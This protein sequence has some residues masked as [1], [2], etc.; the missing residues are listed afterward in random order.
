MAAIETSELTSIAQPES[1]SSRREIFKSLIAAAMKVVNAQLD[2]FSGRVADALMQLSDGST[3]A[4]EASI[5]FN[6]SNLLKKNV[7]AFHFLTAGVIQKALRQEIE[8]VE[9]PAKLVRPKSGEGLSLVPY[10]DMDKKLLL[11]NISRPLESANAERLTAMRLRLAHLLDRDDVSNNQNPFRPEVFLSAIN[12]AWRD[13]NPDGGAHM[14]F[15]PLLKQ[16]IFLDLGVVYDAIN[17]ELIDADILPELADHYNIKKTNANKESKK[18]KEGLDA[19]AMRQLRQ[20]L[21]AHGAMPGAPALPGTTGQSQFDAVPMIPSIPVADIPMIP[22]L[23]GVAAAPGT[24]V[25]PM[26]GA[27]MIPGVP[28][29]PGMQAMPGMSAPGAAGVPMMPGVDTSGFPMITGVPMSGA[30]MMPGMPGMQAMPDGGVYSGAPMM[31]GQHGGQMGGI[32]SGQLFNFLSSMQRMQV[33][34]QPAAQSASYAM[35]TPVLANIKAAAPQGVMTRVDESTVDLLTKIFDVVFRDQNI[36]AEIKGLIGFLQ[37]PVLKAALAD[38]EFFFKEDHPARRLIDMLAKTSVGWDQSKGQDDPLYQT[39]KRNVNRVQQDFDQQA[40]VFSDVVTDLESFLEKEESKSTEELSEPIAQALKQEKLILATNTAKSEVAMR[41]GTG[42]VIAFVETFLESKWVPVLTLAYSIQE[43][44][45][46]AVESALKTMD[47]LI[48]SVKPKI[49]MEERKEL[50]AKLPSMLSILNKWLNLVKLDD[51]ER[52]Q[53]FAEL[54]ECHA[55]IVRAPLEM[56]AE[57]R[58]EIAME[59]A[60]EAAERRLQKKAELEAAIPEPEPDEVATEVTTFERGMWFE[61]VQDNV[62]QKVRLSWVSP[63]RSLYIFTSKDKSNTF[64][65]SAEELATAMREERARLILLGG[66]VDRAISEALE[67]A[68]ANDPDMHEQSAA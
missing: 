31:A 11:S 22:G 20:L 42:E 37:V 3:D 4:K 18:K 23:P 10:E 33:A 68:G 64:K 54:A 28:M 19:A 59:V 17:Q 34:Q 51:A 7:Y 61:F 62:V 24:Q 44:K 26:A 38:K 29:M 6:S 2:Q 67:D 57:R 52:L 49:T 8:L 45:P 14:M 13:F 32:S 25:S 55:S 48:W 15:L 21:G 36:P 40:T 65:L 16:D 41:V 12:D 39:I 27:P 47:D 30:P 58:L 9:A 60:Q 63:M 66:L 53:F 5:S 1:G 56:S 50:I 46:R 43:E 35:P